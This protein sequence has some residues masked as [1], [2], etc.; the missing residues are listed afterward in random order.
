MRTHRP[1]WLEILDTRARLMKGS[2]LGIKEVIKP[3]RLISDRKGDHHR[4]ITS[5][6]LLGM[7]PKS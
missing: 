1:N 6:K 5:L 2:W 3:L 7:V 4:K